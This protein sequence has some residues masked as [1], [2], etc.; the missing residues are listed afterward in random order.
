MLEVLEKKALNE[1]APDKPK[2]LPQ[3]EAERLLKINGENRLAAKKKNSALKIFANQFHDIMVMILLAATVISVALGEYTDAIPIMI[4]VI[5]NALLGFIQEYR[6]EKTLEKLEEMTAPAARVYRD[7]KL[8]TIPASQLV[9]GDTITVE[10]GDR[11]PADGI[12]VSCR[13]FTCDE[14]ILT[15]EAVPVEKR[16]HTGE[17]EFTSLNLPYI[18]YMGTVCTKGNAVIEITATGGLTQMGRVSQMLEDIEPDPTPLQKKLGELGRTLAVICLG[19]CALVFA[20]GVIR[21][22]PVFDMLM[23][24]ISIAIA[25]IPEG[26]PAAVTIALA[27]AV[28]KMLKRNALV[29]RLHSVETLGC[30]TVICTDKTGT[31]TMNRMAVKKVFTAGYMSGE[32]SLANESDSQGL[33]TASGQRLMAWDNQVLSELFICGMA[34]NNARMAKASPS[35]ERNRQGNVFTKFSA[36]GDPTEAAILSACARCGIDV[37]GFQLKRIDEQPFDSE[38]RYMSVTCTDAAGEKYI[39]KKGA[40]DV[41]LRECEYIIADSEGSLERLT[42]REK[43]AMLRKNDEMASGGLRVMAFS[44]IYRGKTIFLGLMGLADP[45]RPEAK[46]AV[47]ECEKAGIKTVMITGDH[48]LTACAVARETGI[49]RE[50][51]LALTGDE[52]DRM[53]D[54][55]LAEAAEKTAVFA[56][57]TP[58]H[59]LRI[60]KAFKDKGHVCAMTGDGVNDAPAVK[61]ASIGVSMGI[62]GTDVTKQAA[63]C[64]LLDDNFATLV[65]AVEEGRTIY[66]NIRKFVRYLI[67]CNIGEVLTM[68]GGIIMGLPM[69]LIPSQILLVNLVTDGLP[70][71]A[72][73]VEPS[74]KS[75]MRKPPRK[76][77][78]SFFSGGLLSRI[79]IRGILIGLCTLAAFTF[80]L[81]TG[82][83]LDAARTGA[84]ITLILSQLIHVFECKSEEK[85]LFSVPYFSNPFLIFSVI[86]SL[87]CLGACMFVPFLSKIFAIAPLGLTGWLISIGFSAA[88]PIA[89]GIAGKLS[90]KARRK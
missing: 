41:I 16:P 45:P 24:G 50:G 23:T 63:D 38:T 73:G 60:I 43:A 2:G 19:V 29:H 69:V 48:K 30:A 70:A 7:G 22:E 26:L 52:L 55:Q 32:Y 61:E 35:S 80:L 59:K 39:Y 62:S 71:V 9:P 77:S 88:I 34:C 17:R 44:K 57:V 83:T 8:E 81:K 87:L 28:R 76:E 51:N 18:A 65:S 1:A 40:P 64:I 11:I 72:L 13:S 33:F 66:Q 4:I 58:A 79:I 84:L 14:S 89:A 85:N 90:S 20:A 53:S 74:E 12:I 31:V 3:Q 5:V 6:C 67:S 10:A 68:L 46:K 56:R 75:V 42:P 37:S 25:A 86:V 82:C 78:D 21:G 36:E 54:D 27:I 49:M 47:R 15:G